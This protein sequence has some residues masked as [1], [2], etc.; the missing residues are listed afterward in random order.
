M[1]N[2]RIVSASGVDQVGGHEVTID[3]KS[4]HLTSGVTV[5]FGRM[6]PDARPGQNKLTITGLPAGTRGITAWITEVL[7]DG[8]PHAGGAWFTTTSV[9]LFDDGRQCR[10]LFT[11]SFNTHLPAA[12]QVM[13]GAPPP[14]IQAIPL[15]SPF[16]EQDR[17]N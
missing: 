15:E 8:T 9:Q 3:L 1:S 14:E 12:A 7:P 11:S 6:T 4:E 16:M 10:V 13:F 5:G 17:I 2:S